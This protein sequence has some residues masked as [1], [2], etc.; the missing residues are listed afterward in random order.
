[1]N[2]QAMKTSVCVIALLLAASAVVVAQP[3]PPAPSGLRVSMVDGGALTLSWVPDSATVVSGF[4]LEGG[5]SPG[6][7]L[8]TLPL[9]RVPSATVTLPAG[10]YFLR[11]RA[12]A[13][14]SLSQPSNEILVRLNRPV[15]PAP[16]VGLLGLA[17]GGNLQLT[18]RTRLEAGVPSSAVLDF[19]GPFSGSIPLGPVET[20]S[21]DGVPAGAYKFSVRATNQFGSSAPSNE[22]ALGFP[23]AC[24]GSPEQPEEFVAY[25]IGPAVFLRWQPATRGSAPTGFALNVSGSID[26]TFPVAS[27]S[28]GAVV[29]AGTYRIAVTANSPCGSS[30]ATPTRTLNTRQVLPAGI[31]GLLDRFTFTAESGRV[32][33]SSTLGQSFSV[34]HAGHANLV[35]DYFSRLLARSIGPRTELYYTSD[36]SLYT[37]VFAFCPSIVIPGG[38]Q[39]TTCYDSGEGIYRWFVVPYIVP[40]YGTLQ[41][42]LSHSFLY[43]T[44]PGAE[45]FPWIKEGT[46]MYWE[47]GTFDASGDLVITTPISYLTSNF[48]RWHS[49]GQLLPLSGLLTLGRDAFYASD[50]TRV[51]SQAGMF[52]LYLMKNHAAAMDELFRRLN[53]RRILTNGQVLSFLTSATGLSIAQLDAAYVAYA[54]TY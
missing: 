32:R 41:H 20:F 40:D 48:R 2:S 9:G 10:D 54:L 19:R 16:P 12:T 11:V 51:Y 1:M 25:N 17:V 39:T 46:G 31:E 14:G 47:S 27:R 7:V 3:L 26:G 42:E 4:Q 28:L 30:I 21:F 36:L 18:W 5:F 33:V 49:S 8:G 38:R 43:A 50:A 24:L 45:D 44:Y 29:P 22:V 6:E 37:E 53:D 35:W 23:G 13:N 52:V 15:P 34:D